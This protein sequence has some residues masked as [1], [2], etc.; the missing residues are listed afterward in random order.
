MTR[1][2]RLAGVLV[3]VA[4]GDALGRPVSGLSSAEIARKHGRVTEMYADGTQG[5]RAGAVTAHTRDAFAVARELSSDESSLESRL[6]G[7]ELSGS[8][9]RLAAV[10]PCGAVSDDEVR[11]RVVG[12]VVRDDGREVVGSARAVADVVAALV[13]GAS[14]ETA[15]DRALSLASERDGP[16]SVRTALAVAFDPVERGAGGPVET[17]EVAAHDALTARDTD[18]ALTTPASRGGPTA[19]LTAV[20]GAIAGARFGDVFPTRWLDVLTVAEKARELGQ[21]LV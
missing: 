3:G 18:D 21:G 4:C 17:L 1:R 11:A 2:D 19:E 12:A 5:D 9:S 6:E 10:T 20:T 14:P 13:G 16:R 7:V 15:T 8:G